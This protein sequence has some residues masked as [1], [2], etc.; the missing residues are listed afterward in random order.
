MYQSARLDAAAR[1]AEYVRRVVGGSGDDGL[2]QRVL[3]MVWPDGPP[4]DQ[5]PIIISTRPLAHPHG[6]H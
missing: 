1:I 4:M 2:I 3:L 6:R 5:K